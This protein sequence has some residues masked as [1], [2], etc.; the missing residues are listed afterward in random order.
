[1]LGILIEIILNWLILWVVCRE[2]LLVL[3][4]RPNQSR[5]VASLEGLGIAGLL[6]VG[7]VLSK[8]FVAKAGWS[9]NPDYD[10]QDFL[11]GSYW[12]VKSVLFEELIFRAAILYVAIKKLGVRKACMLSAIT[13]GI[14]HWFSYGLWG[15]PVMMTYIF[16]LTGLWGLFLA[17]SF[18]RSNSLFVP[19]AWHLG[20][21]LVN[22]VV[23]SQGP[24]GEQLLISSDGNLS[25]SGW[26]IAFTIAQILI[27]PGVGFIYLRFKYPRT[28]SQSV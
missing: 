6:C 12:V 24:I 8:T 23:F 21:N 5:I 25:S 4:L 14:Y 11:S 9:I 28:S 22:I 27:I 10:F 16:I 17:Y 13:F 3:G 20:W 2:H 7:Y 26:Q 1:M 18:V 15:N 19:I